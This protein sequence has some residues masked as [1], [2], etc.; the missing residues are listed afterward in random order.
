[1]GSR[2]RLRKISPCQL[3]SERS[4]ELGAPQRIVARRVES[5]QYLLEIE[6]R[7]SV[8]VYSATDGEAVHH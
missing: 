5:R 4:A 6:T 1:M 8:T 3:P 7:P 2:E